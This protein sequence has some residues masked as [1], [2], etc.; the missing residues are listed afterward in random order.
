MRAKSKS[1]LVSTII[2]LCSEDKKTA[3]R[4]IRSILKQSYTNIEII[5][6]LDGENNVLESLLDNLSS[7]DHRIIKVKNEKNIG[8]ANSLNKAIGLAKGEYT[9]R[10]DADDFSLSERIKKQYTFLKKNNLDL[11]GSNK[12]II[13]G[14]NKYY[15]KSIP[16]SAVNV[17]EILKRKNIMT[18]PT[19]FGKTEVFQKIRYRNLKYSQDYDFICRAI[20]A[21]YKIGNI[22]EY[23]LEYTAPTKINTQK[24]A[25][26]AAAKY[27]IKKAFRK[28]KLS[29]V[30]ITSTIE[31]KSKRKL[32]LIATRYNEQ[33]IRAKEG[34]LYGSFMLQYIISLLLSHTY[35]SELK[36]ILLGKL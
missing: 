19:F 27:E 15:S 6:I 35:R 11:I 33:A 32:F 21:G 13:R 12:I 8:L 36:D 9:A 3:E 14:E 23:L 17:K 10:M 34:K 1:P 30:D 31:K 22:N 25:Y 20:E 26:Q 5:A 16:E 4:A 7:T 29:H 24:K 2:P 28:N 18:H